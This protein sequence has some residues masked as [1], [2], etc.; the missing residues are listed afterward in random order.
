MEWTIGDFKNEYLFGGESRLISGSERM[1]ELGR[2]TLDGEEL[3]IGL[4]M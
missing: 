2:M 4:V 1:G 3:R